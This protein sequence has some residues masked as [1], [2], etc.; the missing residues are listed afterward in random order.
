MASIGV[1]INFMSKI[2]A[3]ILL[4]ALLPIL[5]LIAILIKLDSKGPVIF[6]SDRV[7]KNSTIFSMPK[8]RTMHIGSPVVSTDQIL[9]P[10]FYITRVGYILRKS[11]LDEL[12]QLFSI[13]RSEMSFIGPRP[14]LFNQLEL[15]EMRR[16]LKIDQLNPG[17]T[18]YAQIKARDN[19]SIEDKVR[20]DYYY[21]SNKSFAL[22][23][24]ILIN[25]ILIVLIQKN[26][27][28]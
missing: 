3:V 27:K 2:I 9:Q 17:I 23:L 14:A 28:H 20:L 22:D 11:S 16:K 15:I 12:P 21:L 8:F 24:Y 18:G 13:L 1:L 25:T 6:W 26:I 19:V 4:V 7:G 10:S 5:L